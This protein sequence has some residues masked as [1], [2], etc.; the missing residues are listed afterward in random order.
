MSDYQMIK[1]YLAKQVKECEQAIVKFTNR[2]N[3][4]AGLV[5]EFQSYELDVAL[6]YAQWH[7][8]H[9]DKVVYFQKMLI[10][11]QSRYRDFTKFDPNP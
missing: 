3:F 9:R 8:F 7:R 1:E 11:F 4:D 2:A 6:I 10:E 5:A